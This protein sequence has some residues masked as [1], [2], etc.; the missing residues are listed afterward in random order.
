MNG[1]TGVELAG[2]TLVVVDAPLI[3]R[4]FNRDRPTA[5]P[6]PKSDARLT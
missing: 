3:M 6:L 4:K 5:G 1:A 2:E